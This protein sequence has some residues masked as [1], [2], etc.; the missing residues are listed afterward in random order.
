M[1]R[2]ILSEQQQGLA[3]QGRRQADATSLGSPQRLSPRDRQSSGRSRGPSQGMASSAAAEQPSLSLQQL[4]AEQPDLRLQRASAEQPGLSTK[5]V[6]GRRAS[7]PD[8]DLCAGLQSVLQLRSTTEQPREAVLGVASRQQSG[9]ELREGPLSMPQV[10]LA[11]LQSR[12]HPGAS[13]S[14]KQ[15][16]CTPTLLK[17][18]ASV[19]HTC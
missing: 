17:P 10:T 6:S 7:Q 3:G 16:L 15:Q 11:S 12:T 5:R 9:Q 18:S 4:S 2:R 8:P 1:S 13:C 19:Q 14:C